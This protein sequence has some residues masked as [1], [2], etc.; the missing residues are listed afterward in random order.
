MGQVHKPTWRVAQGAAWG[1]AW[2]SQLYP[3]LEAV[4]KVESALD[5]VTGNQA[6]LN[7]GLMKHCPQGSRIH[8]PH[9]TEPQATGHLYW[10][11]LVGVTVGMCRWSLLGQQTSGVGSLLSQNGLLSSPRF[12]SEGHKHIL[13]PA[14]TFPAPTL[15]EA[16]F[17]SL[18]ILFVEASGLRR[19]LLEFSGKT[20]TIAC[21][22][23]VCLV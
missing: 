12:S 1:W 13:L 20:M 8:R 21:L 6:G 11:G 9:V 4:T 17:Y 7:R 14:L 18:L 5:L 2:R 23:I 3:V 22:F 15:K 10:Q 19:F 16:F